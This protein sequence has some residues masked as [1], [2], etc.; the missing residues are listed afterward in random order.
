MK[1]LVSAGPTR[2][3]IDRVR[4]ISNRSTGRMGFAVA[5][6]AARRGHEVRLVTG[7]VALAG[8]EGVERVDVESA[9]EMAEEILARAPGADAVVMT[10]AVADYTPEKPAAGTLKKSASPLRLTLSRTSDIL[11]ELGG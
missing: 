1:L 10:A 6:E 3:S 4:F 5:G 7:P 11:L 8:P 9:G 2:E